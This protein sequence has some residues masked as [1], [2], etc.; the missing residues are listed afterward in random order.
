MNSTVL[1]YFALLLLPAY[2]SGQTLLKD[3]ENLMPGSGSGP[4]N[5]SAVTE[6][7]FIFK[8]QNVVQSQFL[9]ASDG[10]EVGTIGLG[11]YQV[12]T[13]IIR[14]GNQAFFGGCNLFLSADSCGSLYV[15]DGTVA[16]TTFFFDLDPGG[17]S[18]G[19]EDIAAG[20]SL[21]YFSG[22]T[23]DAG[24]ELWRSNGTVAGTYRIAD[25]APGTANGYVGELAVIDDIAYFAGYTD[26]AGVEAWRS[27][28]TAAGTYMITDLN[29]G[30]ANGQPSGFTASGGYIY[31][32]GLGTNTGQE[33][34]RTTGAQGNIEVIG[35]LGG[36]TDSSWPEQFVDSD[37]RLYYA[38]VGTGSAGHDLYVYDHVGN[39]VHLDF[40]G[41]DIFPRA[42]M[43]FGEGE[44]IFTANTDS[45]GRELWRSD[46][47]LAGTYMITDLYPGEK[48]GVFPTGTPGESFY[49][50]KDSLLYF[51]GA[52][53][54]H[55]ANEFV[56]E[57][58]VSDGTEAGTQL[59][60]DQFPGTGGTNPGNFFEF[61]N[62][63]YF[64]ASDPVVGRE[65]YYLDFGTTTA[66]SQLNEALSIT[67][68][69]FPNP[70]P[71]GEALYTEVKLAVGAQ[72]AT[73]LFD[74][75]GR[76]ISGAQEAGYFPAGTHLLQIQLGQYPAGL[77]HLVLTGGD[78]RQTRKIVLE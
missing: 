47:T 66:I 77:Y 3:V 57:L 50:W 22:H 33:L 2:L 15:S 10:T 8:A 18:L 58:F 64:A 13:D 14:F 36:S 67:Q 48:D 7:V 16:G 40:P 69:P 55:A 17:L 38:A 28:G 24:Y 20:D 74:L 41:G 45:A 44:V 1:F 30:T 65:P 78:V 53:S 51:A 27:D 71:A 32:S 72:I 6:D 61:K 42:L 62:R 39:P 73:Q 43:A 35:E 60:S 54:V 25:I 31:F 68:L 52:D 59:V 34:R 46:G 29:D 37:G 63:L 4:E 21:F 49:V 9:W 23:Q 12:D 11:T 76:A 26:T 19:I 5:W 75:Q 70:V 56:Y